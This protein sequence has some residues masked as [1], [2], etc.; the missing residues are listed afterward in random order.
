MDIIITQG[1]IMIIGCV[2][3]GWLMALHSPLIAALVAIWTVV[4]LEKN[5]RDHVK[6]ML[7]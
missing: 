3:I 7:K 1:L 6:E 5:R 2:S 4:L